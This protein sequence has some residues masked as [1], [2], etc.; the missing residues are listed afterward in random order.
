MQSA[1]SQRCDAAHAS[2]LHVYHT[3]CTSANA[4]ETLALQVCLAQ[5]ARNPAIASIAATWKEVWGCRDTAENAIGPGEK[6]TQRTCTT[7]HISMQMMLQVPLTDGLSGSQFSL[8]SVMH[9][10]EI[11]SHYGTVQRLQHGSVNE[12]KFVDQQDSLEQALCKDCFWHWRQQSLLL[13]VKICQRCMCAFIS[14]DCKGVPK[15][16]CDCRCVAGL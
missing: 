16:H 3:P 4:G 15:S 12:K 7:W 2:L 1:G 11:W 5:Q 13:V 8:Q 6:I 10:H 9:Q 14:D